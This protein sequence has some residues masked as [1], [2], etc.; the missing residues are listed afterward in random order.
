M[1]QSIF[2]ILVNGM[3]ALSL[4]CIAACNQESSTLFTKLDKDETGIQFQNT[5]FDDGSLNI[6]NYSYFYNGGGIAIGEFH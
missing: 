6:L 5:L 3:M 2:K 4:L 1:K